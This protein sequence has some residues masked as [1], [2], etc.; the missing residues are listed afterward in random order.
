MKPLLA[1][2]M[3]CGSVVVHAQSKVDNFTAVNVADNENVSLKDFSSAKA[4]VVIFMGNACAFDQYYTN[5]IKAL[6]ARMSNQVQFILVNSYL[7]QEENAEQ[8]KRMFDDWRL[9]VPY[10]ADKDQTIMS[11][12]G[13]KKSPE[14]FVLKPGGGTF[15]VVYTGA[16]DDNPQLEDAV[17]NRYLAD[18]I[19]AVVAGEQPTLS[20]ARSTGCTIRRK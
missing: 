15:T 19:E 13:A 12:L 11:A 4:V 17:K 5:R 14:A 6:V 2:F 10:L 16:I 18:A 8:M 9:P 3:F 20:N 7:E 1:F